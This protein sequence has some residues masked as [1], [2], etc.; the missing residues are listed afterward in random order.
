MPGDTITMQEQEKITAV[1][2]NPALSLWINEY[3]MHLPAF[4]KSN[5][6]ADPEREESALTAYEQA[7][8]LAPR[9]AILH[10][11]KGQVLEQLGRFTEAE[12]AYEDARSLMDAHLN[13]RERGES[14]KNLL[15]RRGGS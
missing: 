4:D 15:N 14:V 2:G 10:Y 8:K 12:R 13:G 11:H 6:R 1:E 9:E 7:I 5:E 3:Y